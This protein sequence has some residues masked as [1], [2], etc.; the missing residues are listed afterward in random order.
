MLGA[1]GGVIG[2]GGCHHGVALPLH[3]RRDELPE[4]AESDDPHPQRRSQGLLMVLLLVPGGF[5]L[6]LLMQRRLLVL[7]AGL[8]RS[9]DGG[10]RSG[11]PERREGAEVGHV[12]AQEA[13]GRSGGG[14]GWAA[15]AG[16]VAKRRGHGS[17]DAS[18]VMFIFISNDRLTC[19]AKPIRG[20]W[21]MTSQ[22]QKLTPWSRN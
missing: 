3:P 12:T 4:V 2:S 13:A 19:T 6:Q 18:S 10:G 16:E 22:V 21:R 5:S 17:F 8:E 14:A 1:V 20:W 15:E 9:G 7:E 11:G